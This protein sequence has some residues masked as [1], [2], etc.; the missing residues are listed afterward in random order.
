[1]KRLH[2]LMEMFPYSFFAVDVDQTLDLASK[3][4]NEERLSRW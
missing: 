3:E 1:M 2:C 4:C